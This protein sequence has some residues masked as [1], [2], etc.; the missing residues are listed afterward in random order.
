VTNYFITMKFI[1]S[2]FI[3]TAVTSELNPYT[4]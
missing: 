2:P 4:K 1:I 3:L